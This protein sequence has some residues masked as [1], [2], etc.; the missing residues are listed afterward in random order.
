MALGFRKVI[1]SSG[2]PVFVTINECV[3]GGFGLDKAGL[4][5]G[6]TVKAG[7]LM[8]YDEATRKAKVVKTARVYA[9]ATTATAVKVEKGHLFVVGDDIDSVNVDA[10]DTSNASY[11]TFTMASAVTVAAGDVLAS[12][13]VTDL[14]TGL[15]QDEVVVADNE[16]VTIVISGTAFAR[17][18]PP[19]EKSQLPGTINLSKS[20]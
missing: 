17:R 11:D 9:D 20:K 7:T 14:T 4:A 18:I 13:S 10:I 16:S 3:T 8:V 5:D 19:V 15:L 2:I 1:T 6:V 12:Q